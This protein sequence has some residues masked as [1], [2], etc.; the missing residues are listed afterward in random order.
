MKLPTERRSLT[1]SVG[2]IGLVITAW[3][4]VWWIQLNERIA[5]FGKEGI[6][7]ELDPNRFHLEARVGF[8][9]LFAS[10]ISWS[11]RPAG[12]WLVGTVA[13]LGLADLI[14]LGSNFFFGRIHQPFA[15]VATVVFIVAGAV[16]WWRKSSQVV[17]VALAPLYLLTNYFLW[18][19]ETQHIKEAAGVPV[20]YPPSFLNN[21]L[22]DAQWLDVFYLLLSSM[23]LVW[24]VRLILI[25]HRSKEANTP[26]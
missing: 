19:R 1:L 6:I 13:W 11:R 22:C 15:H 25:E 18:Y 5:S 10:A 7:I 16:I 23:M 17:I 14:Y 9:F 2:A 21:T 20:L 8:A 12:K 4:F 24:M 26:A 3:A